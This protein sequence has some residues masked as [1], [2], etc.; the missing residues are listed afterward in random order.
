VS[1]SL[2]GVQEV[3]FTIPGRPISGNRKTRWVSVPVTGKDGKTSHSPRAYS[4][5]EA[6]AFEEHVKALAVRACWKAQWKTPPYVSVD[7]VIWNIA[8]DRDNVSKV[9]C[10]AL[11][12][13]CYAHDSRILDGRITKMTDSNGPRVDVLVRE[14]NPRDYGRK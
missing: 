12:G 8:Q 1:T 4:T 7:L 3:S 9:T 2:L 5:K 11:E 10:D 13:V 6:R 14:V